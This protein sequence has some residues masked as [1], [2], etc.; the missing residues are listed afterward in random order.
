V[1]YANEALHAD[2]DEKVREQLINVTKLPG[3][4]TGAMRW[5]ERSSGGC[6]S[7]R[8]RRMIS[9]TF[10]VIRAEQQMQ[11]GNH[12]CMIAAYPRHPLAEQLRVQPIKGLILDSSG[13]RLLGTLE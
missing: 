11:E 6:S 5:P 3:I 4:S 8:R 9:D 13:E 10:D 1:L 2:M 7:W 12:V